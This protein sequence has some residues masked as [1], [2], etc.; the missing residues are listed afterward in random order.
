[1]N[2]SEWMQALGSRER[3]GPLVAARAPQIVAWVLALAL[4]VQAALILTSLAGAGAPPTDTGPR[5]PASAA[6]ARRIDLA[7]LVNAHLFGAPSAPSGA[8]PGEAPPTTM[9]LVLAGV[10]AQ[11]DPQKGYAIVGESAAAAKLYAVGD[12]IPGGARLHSVYGDRVLIDRNGAIESLPL[13]RQGA[14]ASLLTPSAGQA[15]AASAENPAFERMRRVIDEN[16]SAVGD[17]MRP[18]PVFA[19]GRQR[20]YRVYPGRNRAAFV[21]LGL[22]PGDLVTAINGTPLDDPA[23][24]MEIFRTIGSQ[25]E[26]RVTISRNGRQQD[27]VLN[28]T[29]AAQ[30]AEQLAGAEGGASPV[31]QAPPVPPET[32][33]SGE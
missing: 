20:G 26:V 23:R 3:W 16:P 25:P 30:A 2:A 5:A 22:R 24:G 29:Q 7:A 19:Q 12:S 21:Q 11:A 9:S 33:T 32:S 13:P 27:L 14:G 8:G 17:I 10:L 4:G 18:Q 1:M 6:P 28:M 31:E 15:P